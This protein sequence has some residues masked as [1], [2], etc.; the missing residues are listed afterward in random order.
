MLRWLLVVSTLF[1]FSYLALSQTS[2]ATI[3]GR[4]RDASKAVIQGASVTVVNIDTNSKH[5]TETDANGLFTVVNLLP[6]NYR[7]EVSK[8]GFRTIVKPSMVLHV[9]DVIALNFEMSVGSTLETITVTG[10]TPLVDTE[11]A[12]VG[13]VVDRNFAENLPMNG[14]SFQSLIQLT[15]GVVLTPSNTF[16]SGQF[17]VNGQ[18]A[19]SNYWTVDG[20]SANIGIGVNNL[21]TAGNALAGTQG[22]FSAQGGTNSL[23]SVDALQ[24]FRI[25]TSTY[26]PEFGRT[27][28]GQISIVTRSGTNQFH[29]TAFD[30]LRNDALD[31]NN[32]FNGFTNNPPLP[33]AQERQNDFGG[34][35]GGPLLHDR[36]FF[37]LSYEGLRLRL[38][39]T[40]LTTVP[41]ISAR[42][43]AAPALK[44]YFNAF[45]LP[46]GA[47]DVASGTA[48]FNASFSNRSSLDAYSLR[49]DHKISDKLSIFGRYD[50]SPS[51]I[52]QRGNQSA[53]L[54]SVSRTK[55]IVQTAT[56]V[57][58][59][60]PSP[61]AANDLRFNYSRTNA[62]S[63]NHLDNFGGAVPLA[64]LPLPAP[65]TPQNSYFAF[66]IFSV[67]NSLADGFN[68][69]YVQ[70]QINVADN[71]SLQKG[72][73]GLK[74]GIDYR[75]L[76]PLRDVRLYEQGAF[77]SD[78]QSAEN[79]NLAFSFLVASGAGTLLFRNLSAFAQ[80]TWRALPQLTVTYGARWDVDFAPST[81]SGLPIPAVTGFNLSNPST[82]ALAPAGTPPFRTR[83]G[84]LAPRLGI[85]YQLSQNPEFG[86]VLR[87]GIGLF[88]DLATSEVGNINLSIFPFGG[89]AFNL[90]GT[91]P[92]SSSTAAPPTVTPAGGLFALDPNLRLPY[93]L[94]W[95]FSVDQALGSKETLSASYIGSR[96][97]RLIQTA[98]VNSPNSSFPGGANLISNSAY[99]DYNAL[100]LQFERRL[101]HG[102]QAL[103]SYTWAHS[104]DNASAGSAFGNAANASSGALDPSA[105]RGPSDFDIRNSVS[106]GLTYDL[107]GERFRGIKA[108]LLRNW[109]IENIIQ[110]RSAA[111]VTVFTS[112]FFELTNT[113]QTAV[114]PDLVP[115]QSFYLHGSSFPGGKA[116]NP[117]AFTTPPVDPNT[118]N[119]VR[120]GTLPRNAL[121]GFGAAQWDF[122]IHRDFPIRESLKLQFRGEFFNVL[123]HPNFGAPAADLFD[124]QFG[125][126]LQLLS[127]S[128]NGGNLGGGAFN[129][130]YQIGGPRSIQFALKLVF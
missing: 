34:T 39:E 46:N 1:L 121:R 117:A 112:Q 33:K 6:G 67:T 70:R 115:G 22:S 24:E 87:G 12:A 3:D 75:R 89:S 25:Q 118:G 114:R 47:D 129:P 7:I 29:G 61:T 96:G 35:L 21:G 88:Y 101:S 36:T 79:G 127:S 5:S 26:A 14:R 69:R 92:L 119:P 4:V 20:V 38:P 99:S 128:L 108:A 113:F 125:H 2:T 80:D 50:Y 54:S 81:L 8:L 65:Y 32:W 49:I 120:Q 13:T 116:F 86:T 62:Y 76:S 56:G 122:A 17:S 110:A 93:T 31:A 59:W 64:S 16:D 102:L 53:A 90:G 84:N 30:Y 15:P 11:S 44:P 68:G 95:N 104:I 57:A 52:V 71:F 97:K 37:F 27:P 100:Q 83:Y 111:P 40:S 41:D 48:E 43:G 9:Q 82:L 58:T 10:G 45:P 103:A 106:A 74:F 94:Q 98:F 63:N 55:I 78:V 91:F 77:F 66:D 123:N 73:H 60:L 130:L 109:S 85:A 28:G 18:R 42:M 51:D 124:P 126:S 72:A 19:T 107:Q 105:N 23:V